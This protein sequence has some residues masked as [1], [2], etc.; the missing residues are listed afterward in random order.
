MRKRII[1]S[2]FSV[3]VLFITVAGTIVKDSFSNLKSL[4]D[5]TRQEKVHLHMDKPYYVAGDNIWFKAYV[6]DE[7]S[8][9]PSA[10]SSV[11]YVDLIHKNSTVKTLKLPLDN[12]TAWGDFKL[13]DSIP[14]GSYRIRAYTQWMRNAGE[15]YFFN[16]TIS[17]GNRT[18]IAMGDK[19]N[20]AE[21][22][23][24]LDVQFFSEGG[25]IVK[26]IPTKVAVRAINANG[27]GEKI[28]GTVTN[29]GEALNFTTNELGLG[30]FTLNPTS[31]EPQKA[32]I[33]FKNGIQKEYNLPK[34]EQSGYSLMLKANGSLQIYMS[35]DKLNSGTLSLVGQRNG[36]IYFKQAIT[37]AK[38]MA[39]ITIPTDKLPSGILQL[40][41][42]SANG[43][44]LC[45]RFTFIN[46]EHDKLDLTV[47]GLKTSYG[48]RSPVELIMDV[49]QQ[50]LPVDGSFSVSVTNTSVVGTD[51]ENETNI[52]T[53]FLL[54]SDAVAFIEKPN[55][56]LRK[57]AL[58]DID[59]LM[60]TK[61]W[62]NIPWKSVVKR[63]PA[64]EP[65]RTM[66]ISGTLTNNG[67]PVPDGKVTL[68]KSTGGFD[69][70]STTSDAMGKF[71]FDSLLFGDSTKL[72]VQ[73]RTS[74]DKKNVKILIDQG[75]DQQVTIREI[76]A[77][78]RGMVPQLMSYMRHTEE[79]YKEQAKRIPLKG[80]N[81]LKE[82]EITG[83]RNLRETYVKKH[84]KADQE[85]TSKEL[86]SAVFLSQVLLGEI[87]GG[88]NDYIIILDGVTLLP[89]ERKYFF[90]ET[91]PS[92]LERIEAISSPQLL[93]A[94]GIGFRNKRY[95][96]FV[97]SKKLGTYNNVKYAPGVTTLT[98]KG[99]SFSRTFQ[100]SDYESQNE[101]RPDLRPTVYWNP[102]I[103]VDENGKLRVKY[104]N[105]D[106]PGKYRIVIEGIGG[107]RGLARKELY[108]EV[109]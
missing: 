41:L 89:E 75:Q 93:A 98:P 72:L 23:G 26:D 101:P 38:Q 13:S 68:V 66:S 35:T 57:E 96:L 84:L 69:M 33:T 29:N 2:I 9:A 80:V 48:K 76:P 95:L 31:S 51:L 6:L 67:K 99:F 107:N 42:L 15:V 102:N 90:V 32:M 82:V 71:C 54:S 92:S 1:Y 22:N 4:S 65:E 103:V 12:G 83:G 3:L 18:A 73:A 40:S 62:R 34:V 97:T 30:Y 20:V 19:K 59:L 36:N 74:G 104:F 55:H 44:S 109:K 10:L 43:I 85:F 52:L 60:I 63:K 53:S 24:T 7:H 88:Y 81:Q 28:A 61:S 17:I 47:E 8:L 46:H 16:K 21:A 106:M 91:D 78:E 56:Y 50:G 58:Q 25:R 37:T 105:T 64:F 70:L 39:G 100:S 5:S 14:Q 108:Y 86:D 87:R 27:S 49:K 77:W 45:E 11:L 79:Y 94:Y